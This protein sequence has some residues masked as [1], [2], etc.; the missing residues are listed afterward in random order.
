MAAVAEKSDRGF[1]FRRQ[2]PIGP[3]IADFV[4]PSARLVIEVDGS[5]HEENKEYDEAR[6]ARIEEDGYRVLRF[7]NNEVL[8]N[9]EGVLEVVRGA[10][11][12]DGKW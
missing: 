11:L 2:V 10:L 7:W 8:G 5:Q 9:I 12:N 3:Y 4:C 6:T 1:P